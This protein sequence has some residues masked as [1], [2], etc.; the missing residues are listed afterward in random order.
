M[1]ENTLW[2]LFTRMD[3]DIIDNFY[4]QI[5]SLNI[6]NMVKHNNE[7]NSIILISIPKLNKEDFTHIIKEF[8]GEEKPYSEIEKIL[9]SFKENN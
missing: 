3:L 1:D 2:F 5:N 8:E 9:K 4:N 6:Q 7:D